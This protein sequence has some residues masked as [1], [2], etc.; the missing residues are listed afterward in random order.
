MNEGLAAHLA[1]HHG[2]ATRDEILRSG[3]TQNELQGMVRRGELQRVHLGIYRHAAVP[4]SFDQRL[5]A[6]L[7]AAGDD[8]VVSHRTAL[9]LHGARN[10][11][12]DLVELTKQST[13][14]PLR[15]GLVI[16]RSQRLAP[17]DVCRK[18]GHPVTTPARSIVD[19]ATVMSVAV[20]AKIA[21]EW[22]AQRV[23][24]PDALARAMYAHPYRRNAAVLRRLLADG[25]DPEADTVS[26]GRLGLILRRAGI[27][28]ALHVLVTTPLGATYELDWSY[29]EH[30][31]GL[32]LDG[33]G[34][35]LRSV[36]AFES[37]RDRRNELVLSGWTI[38]N[39]TDSMC[40][41]RPAHVADQVRR[42]IA[43]SRSDA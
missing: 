8:A 6:G 35:H 5:Y 30:R 26:E 41:R 28:P 36:T 24:R 38:L 15:G 3:T 10:F 20:V 40:R 9:A 25:V 43:L 27:P 19:A 11:R 2:I 39:F 34:V 18:G 14:L 37:D 33:Y 31:I 17:T 32:E 16:H 21:E 1:T 12:C 42:A 29:P 4:V 22:M 13:S 7:R 23:V